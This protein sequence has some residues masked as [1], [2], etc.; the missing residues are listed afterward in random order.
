M[1]TPPPG[2][3]DPKAA[4]RVGMRM[5]KSRRSHMP[6]RDI[7]VEFDSDYGAW[8]RHTNMVL[9]QSLIRIVF[10]IFVPFVPFVP[11]VV[12]SKRQML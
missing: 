3:R 2:V 7:F 6:T 11:F 1:P 10:V 4:F 12:N 8:A 5:S 9:R